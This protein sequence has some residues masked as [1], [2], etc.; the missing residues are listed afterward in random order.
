MNEIIYAGYVCGP[1]YGADSHYA[2]RA[3]ITSDL[4]ERIERLAAEV[5][6][7]DV[8]AIQFFDPSLRVF[9]RWPMELPQAI[10]HGDGE[11]EE[12][13]KDENVTLDDIEVYPDCLR[14]TVYEDGDFAWS[15]YPKHGGRHE[16]CDTDIFS[17]KLVHKDWMT[18]AA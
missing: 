10:F 2:Y 11:P 7:L 18:M 17:V 12:P 8:S 14:I 9:S 1:E 15:W 6:R 3:T 16:R 13:D 4:L 5:K